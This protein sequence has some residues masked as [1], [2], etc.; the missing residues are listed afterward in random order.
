MAG[1][2]S[3]SQTAG[4]NTTVGGVSIAEGMSASSVNNGMRA[5]LADLAKFLA[6]IGGA[7][8]TTGSSN[9]YAL[10]TA[11]GIGSHAMPRI[12]AFEANHTNSGAATITIDGLASKSLKRANGAALGSGDIVS[13]SI[14]L[15]AYESGAD[16]YLVLN[17]GAGDVVGPSSATDNAIALFDGTG[18]K[19]LKNSVITAVSGNVAGIVTLTLPNDGLH[20]LDTNASHDLIIAPGS[21]LTADHTLTITTGDADRTLDISAGSVTISAF[22]A[23][24]V[25]DADASAVR[26]TLGLVIGT[27]VQA[28]DATL[29]SLAAVSG[30][31]GDILYAS[32]AD[33]W[34]RLAKGSDG[35]IL[36]LASGVPSWATVT[37]TA[38]N[39]QAFT[40]SDTWTKP[41]SLSA[42]SLVLLQAW[43]AGGS[44]GRAGSGDGAGGGGGGAY[45]Y[46]W[47]LLSQLGSTETVTIGAGG[48]AVTADNT[49][50]NAGG[51]TTI[52]SLLTAYGGGGGGGTNTLPPGGG[53]G[54]VFSA[55]ATGGS[56]ALGA[57]GGAPL[58]GTGTGTSGA[59]GGASTFG[60]GGGGDPNS[61]TGGAGGASV[62]GG[63]GGGG[64]SSNGSG[65]AG[66]AS[67]RGGGG[68][69]GGGD[70]AG[71]SG[72]ASQQAGAGGA[73]AFDTNA[74]TAGTQP[75]GGGGGSEGGD[76]GAGGAGYAR[77]TVFGIPA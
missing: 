50:G 71:G 12:L 8:T 29:T 28:Y 37:S 10:T 3:Y 27:N 60:G 61:G 45:S 26:T 77:V 54:G 67:I 49:A 70:T 58:G 63:G 56:D 6:D 5:T 52:G 47:C 68:G 22:G 48:T 21:N 13:G 25:D 43:G 75:G 65:G 4:S 42:N 46:R 53:G 11:S 76:S 30:V 32:G 44:G 17:A 59:A 31:A 33:A 73:G 15:I 72:G 41:S 69:G 39:V 62:D 36:T 2:F 14:Y 64:G 35:Q 24:V 9:S 7:N 40:S 18:G 66:G 34:A 51:N 16:V 38:P 19:T 74:A 20:L 1:I 57:T 55:G 23:T